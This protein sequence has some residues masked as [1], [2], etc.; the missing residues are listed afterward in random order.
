ML[1]SRQPPLEFDQLIHEFGQWVHIAWGDPQ[2]KQILTIDGN[3]TRP[4]L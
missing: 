3:G 4:G 2:R 1:A